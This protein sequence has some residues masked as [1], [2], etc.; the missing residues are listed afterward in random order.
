MIFN[1]HLEL[2]GRHALFGPSQP[3]WL[4]YNQEDAFNKL[5]SSWSTSVGTVAHAFAKTCI[6][7]KVKF[8]KT[9][10]KALKLYLL[11]NGIQ[12]I[13]I[14]IVENLDLESMS[15]NLSQ[16]VNDA[17]SLR[18][19]TE[20]PL[21]YSELI[22]G[23]TDA[24]SFDDNVLHIHDLKT[25]RQ[26]GKVDQLLSYAGL[27]C[28]EYRIKPV[29]ISAD[30][31]IYQDCEILNY[32]PSPEELMDICDQIVHLNSYVSDTLIGGKRYA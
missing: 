18:M 11:D 7:K 21:R 3:S 24:I 26:P 16:Y 22:F 8:Y 30:L 2:K 27:F 29:D 32:N 12:N 19:S 17:I 9:D 1:E 23:T 5:I 15:I 13:P 20:V 6:D 10:K 25:G 28:L 31:R 14:Y 4:N